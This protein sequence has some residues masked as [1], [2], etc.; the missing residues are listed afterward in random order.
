MSNTAMPDK[1][2]KLFYS[3]VSGMMVGECGKLKASLAIL[4]STR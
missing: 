2:K 4:T 3:V 1:G